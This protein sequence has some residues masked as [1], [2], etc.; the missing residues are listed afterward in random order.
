M[1]RDSFMRF[2]MTALW[3]KFVD[4]YR[5]GGEHTFKLG[6]L[7]SASTLFPSVTAGT[8]ADHG[9]KRELGKVRSRSIVAMS[10]LRSPLPLSSHPTQQSPSP[11]PV[12][13]KADS[14]VH[15]NI[16]RSQSDDQSAPQ[17]AGHKDDD[18]ESSAPW[19]AGLMVRAWTQ[20]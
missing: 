16:P 13:S 17:G 4:A 19:N 15:I 6:A 2:K 10:A 11:L 18:E 14:S 3:E 5:E 20:R 12:H 8:V 9:R 1:E 7:T